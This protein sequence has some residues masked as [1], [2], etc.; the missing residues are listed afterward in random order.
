[1]WQRA[2]VLA[3]AIGGAPL[4]STAP[5]AAQGYMPWPPPPGMTAGAY[6][7]R[8]RHPRGL[9]AAPPPPGMTAGEYAE[10]YGHRRDWGA[11]RPQPGWQERAY[12]RDLDETGSLRGRGQ[13]GWDRGHPGWDGYSRPGRP[14]PPAGMT[15]QEYEAYRAGGGG[16]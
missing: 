14:T 4:L 8:Y 10:R 11:A 5:A 9:G 7:E 12:R 3:L 15:W 2:F 1:M 13:R 6:A 16:G